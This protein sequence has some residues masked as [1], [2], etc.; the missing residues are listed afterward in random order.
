M[1]SLCL[2]LIYGKST[3]YLFSEKRVRL[4]KV[5][6]SFFCIRCERNFNV[7]RK[8]EKK[9][10]LRV[11]TDRNFSAADRCPPRD[12]GDNFDAVPVGEIRTRRINDASSAWWQRSNG[13]RPEHRHERGYHHASINERNHDHKELHNDDAQHHYAVTC[14]DP[15]ARQIKRILS[16]NSSGHDGVEPIVL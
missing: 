8:K 9:D 12:L 6:D 5:Q 10:G 2:P 4:A 3:L 11:E 7:V 1:Y 15:A 16:H 14:G 13:D